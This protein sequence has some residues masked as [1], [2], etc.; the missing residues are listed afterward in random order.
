[1]MV[2]NLYAGIGGNRK[3]WTDVEVTAVDIDKNLASIYQELYP[4]DR[5]VVADAVEYLEKNY[6]KYDFIWAS[7]P[8]QSHTRMNRINSG[9]VYKSTR[10]MTIKVPDFTLYSIIVFLKELFRGKFCVEN[11]M[12]YYEPLIKPTEIQRHYFWSNFN[13][14][15]ADFN[16]G[17]FYNMNTHKND[18]VADLCKY[19]GMDYDKIKDNK[20]GEVST[21]KALKNC[22]HPNVGLHILNESKID[23][24]PELFRK[25]N[26]GT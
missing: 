7:P 20:Y 26:K 19:L 24:Q 16:L 15:I 25:D 18:N 9:V 23:L 12:G 4:N 13:I 6:S 22:V 1:M 14:R 21:K 8:C 3:L 10:N 11:V 17:T 2:L 5:V